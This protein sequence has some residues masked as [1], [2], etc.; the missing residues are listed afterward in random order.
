M[1]DLTFD[2]HLYALPNTLRPLADAYN[3]HL[4][5]S[6]GTPLPNTW[7]ELIATVSRLNRVSGDGTV[8]IS[9]LGGDFTGG[10]SNSI[11]FQMLLEQLHALGI[12]GPR[13]VG[14]CVRGANLDEHDILIRR[15]VGPQEGQ[16][17]VHYIGNTYL[18]NATSPHPEEAWRVLKALTSPE[19]I[20]AALMAH[21]HEL[22]P[23]ISL[24]NDPDLLAAL[25]WTRCLA[26]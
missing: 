1:R 9:G 16:D 23:R 13:I 11:R 21:G 24:F 20:K 4:F 3:L 26:S 14:R 19:S 22:P 17:S 25:T 7:D 18:I 8:E 15:Y 10:A 12:V 6:T 2:G 5:D